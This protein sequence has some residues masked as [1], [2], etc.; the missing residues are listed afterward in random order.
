[1]TLRDE[2][3]AFGKPNFSEEEIAAETAMFWLE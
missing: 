2:L 1:M 3:I